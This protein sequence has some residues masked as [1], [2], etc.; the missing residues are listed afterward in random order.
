MSGVTGAVHTGVILD[1]NG[2]PY[3]SVTAETGPFFEGA[4]FGRMGDWGL[5]MIGPSAMLSGSAVTMRGRA[6]KLFMNNPIAGGGIDSFVA[7]MVGTDISPR[8][9]LD[10]DDQREELQQLWEDSKSELDF[11]GVYD[12]YG[13]QEQVARS[14]MVDGEVLGRFVDLPLDSGLLVPLQVQLLEADHLDMAYNDVSPEGNEIRFGIE[15]QGGKRKRYWL[16]RDHPGENFLRASD[17]SRIGVSADDV[18][19]VFRPLRPGQQRGATWLSRVIVKLHEIDIWDDA[20]IVRKKAAALWG[21]FIYADGPIA[22]RG[23]GGQEGRTVDGVQSIK[24]EPGTFPKL[25]TGYKIEFAKTTDVGN[26][27]LDFIRV[28]FRIIA[29][30]LGI[31]YEQLTGDLTGVNYTSLRAGLIEFRRLCEMLQ[32]RTLIFQWCRPLINRWTRTAVLAGVTKTI[33]VA[34]YLANPR[35][36]QRVQWNPDGWDF[37]DPVKDRVA[38]NLDL[39]Y[40]RDSRMSQVGRM[41]RNV[42]DVDR[43]NRA[44]IDRAFTGMGLVYDA[45]PGQTNQA[46]TLQRVEDKIIEDSLEE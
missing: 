33:S 38:L 44:D 24:L 13:Q 45:Y 20:E 18:L 25:P 2:M 3:P 36:F 27:Y 40:G 46:G 15:W 28:Q 26:N 8:W 14:M 19:H 16:H 17:T 29:K 11:S 12:A 41:G 42:E 9:K 39:R 7:N 21:G 4:T 6:R 30:G 34:E 32:L 10:N 5:S 1:Q 23:V 35:R 31:T 43:E 22:G 37:T